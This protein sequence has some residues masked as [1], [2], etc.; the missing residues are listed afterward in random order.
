MFV[1]RH[2]CVWT[3][4]CK[5]KLVHTLVYR[6]T[7]VRTYFCTD[8]LVYCHTCVLTYLCT[9]MLVY[10]QTYVWTCSFNLGEQYIFKLNV[11]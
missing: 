6:H 4:L 1:Y 10:G 2:T 7:S 3:D 9:D 11:P 8:I 5:N